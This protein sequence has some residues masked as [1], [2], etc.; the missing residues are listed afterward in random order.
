MKR[1]TIFFI[2]ILF[3]LVFAH[4][5]KAKLQDLGVGLIYDD[6]LDIT[7]L[8]NANYTNG[9]MSWD[10][11]VAWADALV[12]Q[13]YDDWR[14]PDTDTSCSGKWCTESEMGHLYYTEGITSDS[15]GPFTDVRPYMYWSATEGEMNKAW[16]FNFSTGYQGF[17]NK[18]L[19]RYAWAVR[20][21]YSSYPVAPE[22]IS[23]VL[24]IAG[25]A[26]LAVRRYRKRM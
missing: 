25:G 6:E 17:S 22:P 7:W 15:P 2:T 13:G 4:S 3:L 23:S 1:A 16:R 20:D 12:F 10:E 8:Q 18:D 26:T 11:A 14:L 5:S 24:F 21:G 9:T 19:T